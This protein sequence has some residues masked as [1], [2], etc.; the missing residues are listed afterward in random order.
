MRN[1]VGPV[2]TLLE[3]TWL[4]A[5]HSTQ[6][7]NLYDINLKPKIGRPMRWRVEDEANEMGEGITSRS[8]TILKL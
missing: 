3:L 5:N 6:V 2:S 8:A 7:V 4:L 1:P